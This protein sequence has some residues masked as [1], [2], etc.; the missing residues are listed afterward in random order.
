MEQQ[1]SATKLSLD[2]KASTLLPGCNKVQDMRVWTQALM[3]VSF[4]YTSGAF[5]VASIA[6]SRAFDCVLAT[7]FVA[8]HLE[9]FRQSY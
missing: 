1:T 4:P 9:Q 7:I 3:I 8:L 2:V 5:S 6:I